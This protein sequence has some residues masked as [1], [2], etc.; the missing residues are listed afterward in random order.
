MRTWI[1]LDGRLRVVASEDESKTR[2]RSKKIGLPSPPFLYTIDQIAQIL[3]VDEK[4]VRRSYLFYEGREVGFKPRHKMRAVNIAEYGD[5]PVWRV[6][7]L[8][9]IGWMRAQGFKFY[10]RGYGA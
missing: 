3:S 2:D 9:L 10:E 6:S 7:E 1:W 8:S 4:T 5:D